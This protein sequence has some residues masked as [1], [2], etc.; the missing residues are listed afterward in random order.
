MPT[1]PTPRRRPHSNTSNTR[2]GTRGGWLPPRL[3]HTHRDVA[4]HLPTSTYTQPGRR[5][6]LYFSLSLSL[7]LSLSPL[8]TSSSGFERTEMGGGCCRP[9]H[10]TLHR[11]APSTN[12]TREAERPQI[13]TRNTL[14]ERLLLATATAT[15]EPGLV[16]SVGA[17]PGQRLQSARVIGL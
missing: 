10:I 3:K 11:T 12:T 15:A 6:S 13:H 2:R 4:S 17:G 7:S 1:A 16:G 9:M 5:L 14:Q 8:T